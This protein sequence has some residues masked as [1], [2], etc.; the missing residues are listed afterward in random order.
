MSVSKEVNSFATGDPFLAFTQG[1]HPYAVSTCA[2]CHSATSSNEGRRYPFATG[3]IGNPQSESGAYAAFMGI[4]L[5]RFADRGSDGHGVPMPIGSAA[6]L[7][8]DQA[9]Q[10]YMMVLEGK[11][12]K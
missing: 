9:L 2:G 6:R 11:P 12:T 7:N 4:G 10:R 8:F 3:P 5:A 1:I